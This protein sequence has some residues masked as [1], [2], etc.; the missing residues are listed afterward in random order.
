MHALICSQLVDRACELAGVHL[1]DDGRL[2]GQV[3]PGDLYTLG[4]KLNAADTARSSAGLW[5][6]K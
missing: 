5:V 3:T 6:A 1:F 4:L 2:S